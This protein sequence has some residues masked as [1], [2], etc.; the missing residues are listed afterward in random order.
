MVCNQRETL[1]CR[2]SGSL[3]FVFPPSFPLQHRVPPCFA[4]HLC[5]GRE[6]RDYEISNFSM[7]AFN[8]DSDS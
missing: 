3:L 8:N 5:V 7:F 1:I 4:H 2:A 6:G